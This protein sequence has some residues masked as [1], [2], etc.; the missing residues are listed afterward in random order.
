[1]LLLGL[2][3]VSPGVEFILHTFGGWYCVLGDTAVVGARLC[4]KSSAKRKWVMLDLSAFTW[5]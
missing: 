2:P 1:M 3:A 5:R 4:S